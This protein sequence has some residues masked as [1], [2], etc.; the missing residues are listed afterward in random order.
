MDARKAG[1][2]GAPAAQLA[3]VR[4]VAPRKLPCQA[5]EIFRA[6]PGLHPRVG[7]G[8]GP[9]GE[10]LGVFPVGRKAARGGVGAQALQAQRRQR[11]SQRLGRLGWAPDGTHQRG[12]GIAAHALPASASARRASASS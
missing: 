9:H 10:R 11:G 5:G 1:S 6:E 3:A 7:S 8:Q 2:A 4:R 12:L